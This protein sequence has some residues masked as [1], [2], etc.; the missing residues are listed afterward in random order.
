M[1]AVFHPKD[2]RRPS[3]DSREATSSPRV[4]RRDE[5]LQIIARDVDDPARAD[6][7]EHVTEQASA[8]VR[9]ASEPTTLH[10]TGKPPLGVLRDGLPFVLAER[11]PRPLR[12]DGRE[13]SRVVGRRA[14]LEAGRAFACHSL[15]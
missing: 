6:D 8:I 1:T 10:A 7:R 11:E 5:P 15:S 2:L 3:S 9:D 4:E 14:G 13:R 12:Q